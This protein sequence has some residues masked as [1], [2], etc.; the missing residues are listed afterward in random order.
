MRF[1]NNDTVLVDDTEAV[2]SGDEKVLV[3]DTEAVRFDN[4]EAVSVND[5]ETVQSDSKEA[6]LVKGTEAVMSD[7]GKVLV[8]DTEAVL[9]DGE[10][11]PS[12]DGGS[13]FPLPDHVVSRK[14][15]FRE[16]A[17]VWLGLGNEHIMSLGPY[18][19]SSLINELQHIPTEQI[20]IEM[21]NT[22]DSAM[23][24]LANLAKIKI[25]AWTGE[26]WDWWP[27]MPS[28][29]EVQEN[30]ARICWTCVSAS[31]PLGRFHTTISGLQTDV[32]L[33]SELRGQTMGLCP[34]GVR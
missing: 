11:M 22:A 15:A 7:D 12:L 25:E 6:V 17:K 8:S 13:I 29:R 31:A 26:I 2:P 28:K 27:L 24:R 16:S 30:E 5:I 14:A 34:F 23:P 10:K 1:D 3:R 9:I 18:R 21:D 32:R 4:N 20:N 33:V 19:V